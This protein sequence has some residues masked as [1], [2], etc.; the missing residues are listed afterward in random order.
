[1]TTPRVIE[2]EEFRLVDSNG[3]LRARV[4]TTRADGPGCDPLIQLYDKQ[5]VP[6]LT[7]ELRN[8]LPRVTFYVPS[9]QPAIAIG[10]HDD[11]GTVL[12]LSRANGTLGVHVRVPDDGDAEMWVCDMTGQPRN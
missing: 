10:V 9:G 6:R 3:K 4:S 7:L 12:S 5:G 2:A 11:G 1:M 8:D